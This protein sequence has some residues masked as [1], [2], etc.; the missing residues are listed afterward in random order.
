MDN[1]TASL[2]L[3]S[4][5]ISYQENQPVDPNLWDSIFVLIS[6]FR[7]DQYIS[8]NTQNITCFLLQIAQFIKQQSLGDKTVEDILLIFKFGAVAWQFINAIY[9]SGW[10]KLIADNKNKSFWQCVSAQF[11]RRKTTTSFNLKEKSA[12]VSRI[13]PSISPRPNKETLAKLKFNKKINSNKKSY[14]QTSKSNV[15]NIICIKDAFPK[16]PTKKVIDIVNN[17]TGQAKPKINM[18]TKGPS[19][20][21][22]IISMSENYSEVISNF[23][24][25]TESLSNGSQVAECPGCF[26]IICARHGS[27]HWVGCP[28]EWYPNC[29]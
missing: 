1:T 18:T 2:I 28:E 14:T 11:D 21:Q 13:P 10:D 5:A 4:S 15:E 3:E 27:R 9:E 24:N 17:K 22:I 8:G 16:L 26:Q 7:V 23:A 29:C 6:I 25:S 19:R 12:Q 20:K